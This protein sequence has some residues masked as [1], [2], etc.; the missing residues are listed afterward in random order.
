MGDI[1]RDLKK[2]LIKNVDARFFLPEQELVRILTDDN[3]KECISQ[4]DMEEYLKHDCIMAILNG[5]RRVLALLLML[6]KVELIRKFVETDQSPKISYLDSRLPFE[7]ESLERILRDDTDAIH[8][9]S[10]NQWEVMAPYFQEEQTHRIFQVD[11][12]M[13][14]IHSKSIGAGGFGDVLEVT[15]PGIHHG[16]ASHQKGDVRTSISRKGGEIHLTAVLYRSLSFE[17]CSEPR[18]SMKIP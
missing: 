11:V 14:F 4:A 2:A 9:I 17:R 1:R 10:K 18:K 7:Q 12:V 16:F 6:K 3:V 8:D 13:P 5:G 15:L